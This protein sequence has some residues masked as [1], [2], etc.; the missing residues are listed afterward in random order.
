M[1]GDQLPTEMTVEQLLECGPA[2]TAL[3]TG[4]AARGQFLDRARAACYL[5]VDG[6]IVDRSAVAHVHDLKVRAT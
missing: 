4:A 6:A 3:R 5:A 1:C 2:A